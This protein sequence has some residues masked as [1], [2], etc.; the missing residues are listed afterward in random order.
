MLGFV[1][2]AKEITKGCP[3]QHI[4]AQVEAKLLE[5][6]KI[7]GKFNQIVQ[8]QLLQCTGWYQVFQLLQSVKNP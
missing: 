3:S 5:V 2:K 4:S 7:S 6:E 8:E 1:T